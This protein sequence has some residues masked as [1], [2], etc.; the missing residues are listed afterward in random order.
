MGCQ[1]TVKAHETFLLPDEF[2]LIN[3]SLAPFWGFKPSALHKLHL[4]TE[5]EALEWGNYYILIRNSSG[6][7]TTAKDWNA[8]REE[9]PP[10]MEEV[11]RDLEDFRATISIHDGPSKLV[12]WEAI[13][14]LRAA[15]S[16][17]ECE[18]LFCNAFHSTSFE[19]ILSVSE[20]SRH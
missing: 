15:A 14:A 2:D 18:S 19:L 8:H 11:E 9:Y 1:A 13:Q 16:S 12:R 6:F 20:R 17:E 3:E 4:A 10:F 7:H 5:E